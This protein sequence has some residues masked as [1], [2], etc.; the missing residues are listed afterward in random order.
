M[1]PRL[2]ALPTSP[3][4]VAPW[5]LKV[6]KAFCFAYSNTGQT[7]ECALHCKVAADLLEAKRDAMISDAGQTDPDDLAAVLVVLEEVQYRRTKCLLKLGR[8]SEAMHA[9]MEALNL[10]SD[11]RRKDE[12]TKIFVDLLM[13]DRDGEKEKQ[14]N[15]YDILGVAKDATQEEIKKAYRKLALKYHPDKNDDPLAQKMFVELSDAYSILSDPELRSQYDG[16]R[17]PEDLQRTKSKGS[18][19]SRGGGGRDAADDKAKVDDAMDTFSGAEGFGAGG[20]TKCAEDDV[21]CILKES[22]DVEAAGSEGN[23]WVPE[24]CCLPLP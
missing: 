15:L 2:A 19:A 16:G 21:E 11:K 4:A 17:S 10:T 1:Q 6:E 12:L 3:D 23:T 24:H 5:R 14:R 7:E 13:Q 18:S 9:A 20:S 22:E 8:L